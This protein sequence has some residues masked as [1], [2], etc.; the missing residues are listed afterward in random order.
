MKK[1]TNQFQGDV[2]NAGMLLYK[3]FRILIFDIVNIIC[4]LSL[5]NFKCIGY[6]KRTCPIVR[7]NAFDHQ[8]KIE[9]DDVDEELSFALQ[10]SSKAPKRRLSFSKEDGNSNFTTHDD[11]FEVVKNYFALLFL[12]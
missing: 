5:Y 11:T 1:L 9:F 7:K 3:Y 12:M 4:S 8:S 2:V 6:T 10:N